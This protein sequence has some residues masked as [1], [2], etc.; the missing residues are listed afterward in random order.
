MNII[1]KM[2]SK[3]IRESENYS[4]KGLE[5]QSAADDDLA[6]PWVLEGDSLVLAE[7]NRLLL[8]FEDTGRE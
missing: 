2:F 3:K 1:K 7:E 6:I 8:K 4:K 5:A